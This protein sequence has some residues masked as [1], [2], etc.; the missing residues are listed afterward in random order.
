M[1]SGR[2]AAGGQVE[3]V[4]PLRQACRPIFDAAILSA[5]AAATTTTAAM[6]ATSTASTSTASVASTVQHNHADDEVF[7]GGFSQLGAYA[8]NGYA[9][10]IT[11][12]NPTGGATL[13]V[14]FPG[15]M[16][17]EIFLDGG[18]PLALKTFAA[19]LH[20]APCAAGG[21]GHYQ[22][23]ANP[24][25][26]NA[27]SENWPTL[28]CDAQGRCSGTATSEWVP[29]HA[30]LDAGLSVVI[31]DTPNSADGGS[32]VTRALG[33]ICAGFAAFGAACAGVSRRWLGVERV[34]FCCASCLKRAGAIVL[35]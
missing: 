4:P 20:S 18:Q 8:G 29:A 5:A 32:G 35:I 11:G 22:D 10:P 30:A 25:V 27:I 12:G 26:V 16:F 6:G 7:R 28:Q 33:S 9:S 31:H 17:A 34:P 19:H 3:T 14:H 2:T 1:S 23:P 21:G 15:S 24:G 13:T